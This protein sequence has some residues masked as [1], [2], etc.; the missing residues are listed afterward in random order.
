MKSLHYAHALFIYIYLYIYMHGNNMIC[1]GLYWQLLFW[2]IFTIK[3]AWKAFFLWSFVT[4]YFKFCWHIR[5]FYVIVE[6]HQ[7]LVAV[8]FSLVWNVR[9]KRFSS[10]STSWGQNDGLQSTRSSSS[11]QG[12]RTKGDV[13]S[14]PLLFKIELKPKTKDKTS[15]DLQTSKP[16]LLQP[17]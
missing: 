5:A 6:Q 17:I 9:R 15:G 8:S 12:P 10:Y 11:Y 4:V 7:R 13:L 14:K 1:F 16:N 3:N 2:F